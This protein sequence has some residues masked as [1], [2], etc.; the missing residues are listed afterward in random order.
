MSGFVPRGRHLFVYDIVATLAAVGIAFGL[1]FDNVL[2]VAAVSPFM[3]VALM[4]ILVMPPTYALFGLYRREWRYASVQEMLSLAAAVVV[5]TVVTAV[6]VAGLAYAGA[7]GTADFPKSIFATEAL[8]GLALVGGGR[9]AV[10]ANLERRGV[11]GGTD[12]E[13]GLVSTIVYGAGETG[14]TVARLAARDPAAGLN[15]VGFIDDDA[16]KH[17][18][19]L[20]GKRVF[21]GL[22]VLPKVA[23]ETR[24]HQLLVAMPTASGQAVRRAFERGQELGL[25]V[26]TIPHPRELLAG[27]SLAQRIRDVSVDDLLRREPVDIDSD[28]VAGYLN[29]AS[30][31][32]TGGGGSIGSELVRQILAMGPRLL[33][34]VENHEEALWSIERELA[35]RVAANPGVTFDPILTDIRSQEAVDA[36][37]LRARPDV[38]FHAAALKHVPMVEQAP[39]EGAMTNVFGSQNVI[40]ACERLGVKRFVLI[41]TDKA[42]EPV[43]A[44]G[45]TKR[46]AELLTVA[47]ARRTGRPYVA[48]RFGNVL[49]SSGSVIPIFK[50][51]LELG[52]PITITHA[53][54]TR[55]FMTIP[56]AVSLILQAGATT[57]SGVI[58]VLDMGDPVKIVDLARDLIHLSGLS[59][60][61]VPIVYTGLRAGER[62]HETLFHDHETT[63]R[64]G[65]PSIMRVRASA[66]GSVGAPLEKLLA[67]L[68]SATQR[69][70][71]D[72]VREILR[73]VASFSKPL[74]A[75]PGETPDAAA[76]ADAAAAPGTREA[77]NR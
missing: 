21:G 54:A 28:A 40:S 65:H 22:D 27:D 43:S 41:S 52:K 30:V 9:F 19:R 26:R 7:P 10:R 12:E 2:V 1:R 57:D 68:A 17:G 24:A 14:A 56:E 42:V 32:V 76:S 37:I 45:A 3:P 34:V 67:E 35:D 11:S 38:V 39:A 15:V 73:T 16:A 74:A 29:G 36:A 23:R 48:V 62:L 51:Q 64:T 47:S 77:G 5:G 8:L 55:Y 60:A 59:E 44:M 18:S 53:D 75:A 20:M 66:V 46:L 61:S 58:F 72:R 4:P 70:D 71:D 50:R 6:A 25:Q 63:D 69:H 33:T 49:G 31:L 13:L